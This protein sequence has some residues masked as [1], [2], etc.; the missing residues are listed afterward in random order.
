MCKTGP[1]QNSHTA[2]LNSRFAL[3][4]FLVSRGRTLC[5]CTHYNK[6]TFVP[7]CGLF[8]LHIRSTF[9]LA[10]YENAVCTN[11]MRNAPRKRL[12]GQCM[13]TMYITTFS[14]CFCPETLPVSEQKHLKATVTFK[15]TMNTNVLLVYLVVNLLEKNTFIGMA[16]ISHLYYLYEIVKRACFRKT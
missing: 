4:G 2:A 12:C 9:T 7:I 10:H 1:G 13:R 5:V 3:L 16:T 11:L 15:W 6:V 14:L 8:R